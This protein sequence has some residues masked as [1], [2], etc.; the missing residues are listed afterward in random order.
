MNPEDTDS[1]KRYEVVVERLTQNQKK[2]VKDPEAADSSAE[3]GDKPSDDV[4]RDP[5]D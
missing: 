1:F 4:D 5:R 2:E 3:A